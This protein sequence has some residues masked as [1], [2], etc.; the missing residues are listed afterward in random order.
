MKKMILT[1]IAVAFGLM[2]LGSVATAQP[3]HGDQGSPCQMHVRGG[4][5]A[6]GHG[7]KGD[8]LD[9]LLKLADELELTEAQIEQLQKARTEFQLQM[10]DARAEMQK[11][12]IQLR[13]LKQDADVSKSTMFS[14]IDDL[15]ERQAE[16]KKMQY[17]HRR[18][19]KSVLTQEQQEKAKTL[20]SKNGRRGFN[21][22]HSRGHSNEDGSQ[23]GRRFGHGSIGR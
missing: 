17:V 9:H 13:S 8:R 18:E 23:Q 19:M 11:A 1:T 10:V 14:A 20:R 12:R 16:I 15:S 6:M 21:R 5:G 4:E 22:G 7:M 2:L 3:G